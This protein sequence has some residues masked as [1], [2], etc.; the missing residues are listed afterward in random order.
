MASKNQKISFLFYPNKQR[1]KNGE[2]QIYVRL[3]ADG[4][5]SF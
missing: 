5:R 2:A 4:K 3:Y 1:T